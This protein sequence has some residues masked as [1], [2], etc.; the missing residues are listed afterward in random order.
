MPYGGEAYSLQS[1]YQAESRRRPVFTRVMSSELKL[2]T[3]FDCI[4][5]ATLSVLHEQGFTRATPV[6]E[7]VIPLFCSHKDVAVDAA[8]GSGKTLSFIV[9]IVERLHQLASAPAPLEVSIRTS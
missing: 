8:T 2:F 5:S 4:S 1:E 7:A 9:P 3:E 6:Q